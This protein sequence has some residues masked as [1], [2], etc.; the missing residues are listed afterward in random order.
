MQ[1]TKISSIRSQQLAFPH[2]NRHKQITV[3]D[4]D[5]IFCKNLSTKLRD[6]IY[7]RI[8]VFSCACVYCYMK[9]SMFMSECCLLPTKLRIL[10]VVIFRIDMIPGVHRYLIRTREN[11]PP[12]LRAALGNS[13]LV[14]F[15]RY[16]QS[17]PLALVCDFWKQNHSLVQVLQNRIPNFVTMP[18]VLSQ[19]LR[20][21][22]SY[23][24]AL[25]SILLF[26]S[27]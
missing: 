23:H 17:S 6:S 10:T 14:L 25:V 27:K 3:F 24:Y 26:I 13:Y 15:D 5:T 9:L 4:K 2:S 20:R 22:K 12:P 1:W 21:E 18:S 16:W 19:F 8:L 7:A 11:T